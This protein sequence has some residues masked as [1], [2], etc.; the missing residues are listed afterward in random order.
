MLILVGLGN[1]G[2][3]YASNRHN[4]G[5]MAADVIHT[6]HRFPAWRKNFQAEVSEGTIDGERVLL[7]KPQTYMNESGRSVGDAVRFLKLTPSDVVVIH[8]ELDLPPGSA[9]FKKGGGHGG[10]NGLRDIHSALGTPDY[11]RL[12]LGIGH[13]GDKSQVVGFVLGKPPA[14]EQKM[15]DEAIDES[16]RCTEMLMKD[17]LEKTVQRLHSFKA[18]A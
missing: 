2:A 7:M 8:D 18:Q 15:I 5:F 14:S 1:P 17:G 9:R 11:W 4:I 16:L 12:R 6:R 13:P 3:K 10:H